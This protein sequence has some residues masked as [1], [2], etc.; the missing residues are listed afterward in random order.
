MG[1]E[2][3]SGNKINLD[4]NKKHY[5]SRVING[6]LFLSFIGEA[7][8]VIESFVTL[9]FIVSLQAAISGLFWGSVLLVK[10]NYE[11]APLLWRVFKVKILRRHMPKL[12]KKI[13]QQELITKRMSPELVA[14]INDKIAYEEAQLAEQEVAATISVTKAVEPI[15]L[16]TSHEVD[17]FLR[18]MKYTNKELECL[19]TG[20]K[21]EFRLYMGTA[22]GELAK[23]N[24]AVSIKKGKRIEIGERDVCTNIIAF[25]GIGSGKTTAII[26]PVL[27]QFL[28]HPYPKM[29]GLVFDIKGDFID[30]D[31]TFLAKD[32]GRKFTTIG[33]GY[34]MKGVNLMQGLSPDMA[35]TFLKSVFYLLGGK[36]SETYWIDT[37][38][39]L[40]KNVFG[41]LQYIPGK[42]NLTSLYE[43]CF[44]EEKRVEYDGYAKEEIIRREAA[45]TTAEE[46]Q[47][48]M[49]EKRILQTYLAF[50][51]NNFS[52]LEPKLQTG[53][54]SSLTQILENFTHPD[55][56]DTF[57][58]DNVDTANLEDI[59]NKGTVFAVKLDLSRWG[60]SGK[61]ILTFIK[62]RYFNLVQQ[63]PNRRVD[64]PGIP[65]LNQD[66]LVFMCCDEYQSLVSA[67]ATAGVGDL[68]YWDK[69]RSAKSIGLI[70]SQS[71]ASMKAAI[72]DA[73]LTS[74]ILQ[75]FR[76]AQIC[77]RTSDK[78]TLEYFSYL[79]GRSLVERV[80]ESVGDSESNSTNSMGVNTGGNSSQSLSVQEQTVVD[81]QLMK[82]MPQNTALGYFNIDG[83]AWDD[84][85]KLEPIYFN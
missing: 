52:K 12:K 54:T 80:S 31:L 70:S 63:R 1:L 47:L 56:I 15:K 66:R 83:E 23:R 3:G 10:M 27:R 60:A 30:E 33:V 58:N 73:D 37:A 39:I 61:A 74:T 2:R 62:L 43:Y 79:G 42:Y 13:M 25:G 78:E 85:V 75:N 72:G 45:A 35:S 24:H 7:Y 17:Y 21:E 69:A 18:R 9:N 28:A 48:I 11:H 71:Y 6:F 51:E 29:G 44:D 50:Y 65:A 34:G 20:Q 64:Q 26:R 84:V 49:R 32:V 59:I 8:T 68:Q 36:T 14:K 38:T 46:K 41:V 82:N 40:S 76:G 57:C 16:K 53:V 22:T 81:V 4:D 55:L 19:A 77:L 67:N 5:I